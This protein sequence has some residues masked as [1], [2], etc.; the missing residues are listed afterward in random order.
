MGRGAAL[1]AVL[2]AATAWAGPVEVGQPAPALEGPVENPKASGEASVS[3]AKWL[4][5][6]KRKGPAKVVLVSFAASW[7]RPCREELPVIARLLEKHRAAGLRAVVLGVDREAPGKRKL[8]GLVEEVAPTLP[9]VFGVD[10]RTTL[11]WLGE[12]AVVPS[13]VVVGRG[14]VVRSV[15]RAFGPDGEE[16]L[17]EELAAALAE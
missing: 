15:R 10:T 9:L 12:R 11:A 5:A 14:G 16:A 2:L 6:G 1:T 3:L 7:C 17:A 8:L 13:V 4:G